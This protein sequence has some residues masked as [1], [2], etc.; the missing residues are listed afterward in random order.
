MA[1]K[2]TRWLG[3]CVPVSNCST[4]YVLNCWSD[5]YCNIL[6]ISGHHITDGSKALRKWKAKKTQGLKN[7]GYVDRSE[8]DEIK[9]FN[10]T[11]S[12]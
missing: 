10:T 6:F 1:E 7:F 2:K 4:F 11:K 5:H 3:G 9:F 12:C 8:K